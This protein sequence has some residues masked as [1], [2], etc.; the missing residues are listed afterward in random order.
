[1]QS[2]PSRRLYDWMT[3]HVVHQQQSDHSCSKDQ[4]EPTFLPSLLP[5]LLPSLS[6]HLACCSATVKISENVQKRF[7]KVS[8]ENICGG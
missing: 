3:V 6:E 5:F 8:L 1:M 4:H 2:D 7:S